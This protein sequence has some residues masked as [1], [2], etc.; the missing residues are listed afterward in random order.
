[1]KLNDALWAYQ[2]AYKTSLGITP[3]RLV[4]EKFGHLPVK[5]EHKAYCAIQTLKFN[6]KAAGEWRI[7]QLNEL[8]EMRL[9]A[10]E[11]S[12]ID[13]REPSISMISTS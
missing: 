4:F 8:N 3:Y 10:Y 6:L 1:M 11:S 7:L 5:L 13:K 9:E 2:T 12:R